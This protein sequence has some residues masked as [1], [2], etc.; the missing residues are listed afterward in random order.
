LTVEA[1]D[2]GDT[3][4]L[5]TGYLLTSDNQIDPTTGTAKENKR[6]FTLIEL[7]VV[8]GIIAVILGYKAI[9]RTTRPHAASFRG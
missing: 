4:N 8:I 3:Q 5:A 7:L 6:G 1:Y 2:R 9:K